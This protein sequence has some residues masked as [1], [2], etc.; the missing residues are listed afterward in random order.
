VLVGAVVAFVSVVV[1]ETAFQW[2]WP[3]SEEFNRALE[4]LTDASKSGDRAAVDAA[5]EALGLEVARIPATA[6]WAVIAGWMG[7]AVVGGGLAALIARGAHVAAAIVVAL[8]VV[9]GV[10][11]NLVLIPHPAWMAAAAPPLVLAA[12]F[13]AGRCV[14]RWASMRASR[15]AGP[16]GARAADAR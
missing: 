15:A 4:A 14:R 9:I 6:K 12:G 2:L 13:A 10:V 3:P 5:R 16:P 8:F 11:S 1:V 7:A